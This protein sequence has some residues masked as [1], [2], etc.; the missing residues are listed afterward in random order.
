MV[1]LITKGKVLIK[2][3]MKG[4]KEKVKIKINRKIIRKEKRKTKS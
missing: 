4:K 1:I 3:K 2:I